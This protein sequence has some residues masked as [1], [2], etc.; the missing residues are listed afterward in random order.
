MSGFNP[1]DRVRDTDTGA[2]GWMNP[3][4]LEHMEDR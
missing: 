3:D 2:T 4:Y 1:G